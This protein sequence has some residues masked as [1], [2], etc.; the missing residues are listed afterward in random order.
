M[1]LPP[2]AKAYDGYLVLK[3]VEAENAGQYRCTATTITQYATDDA[4]LTISKRISLYI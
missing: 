4:L 2:N 3:G 1:S